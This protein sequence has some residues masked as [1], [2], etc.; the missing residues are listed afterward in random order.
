MSDI[1][2]VPPEKLLGRGVW[3]CV[4]NKT[5]DWEKRIVI[6][7]L[8][9]MSLEPI[10][11]NGVGRCRAYVDSVTVRDRGGQ[12]HFVPGREAFL[13]KRDIPYVGAYTEAAKKVRTALNECNE[14]I[15]QLKTKRRQLMDKL[16][17][18]SVRRVVKG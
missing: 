13:R 4:N 7:A 17:W 1:R 8:V 5:D 2:S 3:V 11:D 18:L 12:Q 6:K 15:G 10:L 9:P 16:R 14:K